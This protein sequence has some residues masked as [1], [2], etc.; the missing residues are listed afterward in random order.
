MFL[1]SAE[2]FWPFHV[3]SVMQWRSQFIVAAALWTSSEAT[4]TH[5]SLVLHYHAILSPE[6]T[7]RHARHVTDNLQL[8]LWCN[9]YFELEFD[10]TAF[11]HFLIPTCH[12][13]AGNTELLSLPH[14]TTNYSMVEGILCILKPIL[15]L[16]Y[17]MLIHYT[18]YTQD[19]SLFNQPWW[20][21]RHLC[22]QTTPSF[23]RGRVL[24]FWTPP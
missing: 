2:V 18:F 16:P 14:L 5:V 10:I 11:T 8:G 7:I 1:L 19:G 24:F 12:S 23:L 3:Y 13:Q 15:K 21:Q 17:A 9:S 6:G 20:I 4:L 22:K